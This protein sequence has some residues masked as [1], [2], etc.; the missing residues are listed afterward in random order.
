MRRGSRG[1]ALLVLGFRF[2]LVTEQFL[3]LKFME[4]LYRAPCV[5]LMNETGSSWWHLRWLAANSGQPGVKRMQAWNDEITPGNICDSNLV[6]ARKIIIKIAIC[7][8]IWVM[9]SE[10]LLVSLSGTHGNW[11]GK[12]RSRGDRGENCVC[13]PEDGWIET[14]VHKPVPPLYFKNGLITSDSKSFLFRKYTNHLQVLFA[15]V[16][17]KR[18]WQARTF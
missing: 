4:R 7:C 14:S 18:T 12:L 2:T 11:V 5:S 3:V 15:S 1:D 16:F 9:I 10:K 17:T 6:P 13:W 8:I